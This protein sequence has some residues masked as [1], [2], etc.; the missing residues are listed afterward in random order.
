MS[1]S[2]SFCV[3]LCF[4]LLSEIPLIF[5][6]VR[7]Y[8]VVFVILFPLAHSYMKNEAQAQTKKR[9]LLKWFSDYIFVPVELP[10]VGS[11]FYLLSRE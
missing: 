11:F 7:L 2:Y 3:C 8:I 9:W 10:F 5:S 1:S 4:S 6:F